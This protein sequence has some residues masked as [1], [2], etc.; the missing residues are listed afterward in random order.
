MV[1]AG[2]DDNRSPLAAIGLMALA[3][4]VVAKTAT[5]TA[6]VAGESHIAVSVVTVALL[7]VSL[8]LDSVVDVASV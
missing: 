3:A 6:P 1:A 7:V 8:Y 2:A 4:A 5:A